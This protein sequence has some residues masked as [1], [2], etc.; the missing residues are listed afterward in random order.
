MGSS[1]F[2]Q[3]QKI[4]DADNYVQKAAIENSE[5]VSYMKEFKTDQETFMTALIKALYDAQYAVILHENEVALEQSAIDADSGALTDNVIGKLHALVDGNATDGEAAE[6]EGMTESTLQMLLA[7]AA[8][9]SESDKAQ[10]A[11]LMKKIQQN[12]MGG[13]AHLKN[14]QGLVDAINQAVSGNGNYEAMKADLQ[15]MVDFNQKLVDDERKRMEARGVK[16]SDALFFG[17]ADMSQIKTPEAYKHVKL[18]DRNRYMNQAVLKVQ[19]SYSREAFLERQRKQ[20]DASTAAARKALE[21][22]KPKTAAKNQ[23]LMEENKQ[24]SQEHPHW[25]RTIRE[26]TQK[27]KG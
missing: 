22:A 25:G 6:L 20:M 15:A 24:L 9:G 17:G 3:L 16:L 2:T 1:A 19:D 10:I 11:L 27:V 26:V 4:M 14:A 21:Q 13:L 7:K 8:N 18:A 23:R 12:G 5:L